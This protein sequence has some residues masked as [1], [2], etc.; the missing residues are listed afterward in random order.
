MRT[1]ICFDIDEVISSWCGAYFSFIRKNWHR[2]DIKD[3][4]WE[5]ILNADERSMTSWNCFTEKFGMD[6]KTSLYVY[7]KFCDEKEFARCP[8][9]D[10]KVS[11]GLRRLKEATRYGCELIYCT[12]RPPRTIFDT[13]ENFTRKGIPFDTIY[14]CSGYTA[15]REISRAMYGNGVADCFT[16][17]DIPNVAGPVL[18]PDIKTKSDVFTKEKPDVVLD[19]NPDYLLEAVR[20]GV[21]RCILVSR[22]HNQK[23]RRECLKD[24]PGIIATNPGWSTVGG[25][26]ST[27]CEVL[28]VGP[29]PLKTRVTLH[30]N[31]VKSEAF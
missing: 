21:P 1:K 9:V 25:T 10:D 28:G 20:A 6:R 23:W 5:G 8:L 29:I 4:C 16:M 3:R 2:L 12:S 11:I 26:L 15:K 22:R 30:G 14:H 13:V 19:D 27:L 18:F 31:K 7:G 24:Y 17:T